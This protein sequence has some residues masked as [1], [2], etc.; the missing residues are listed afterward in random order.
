MPPPTI[1]ISC[2]DVC[3]PSPKSLVSLEW[4]RQ[5]RPDRKNPLA[6]QCLNIPEIIFTDCF[7]A[8]NQIRGRIGWTHQAPAVGKRNAQSVYHIN[9]FR[10]SKI[11]TINELLHQLKFLIFSNRNLELRGN[12]T[13]W[14]GGK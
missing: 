7:K 9:F 6:K 14:N 8:K 1:T 11:G 12:Q 2:D 10:I 13:V 5:I 4:Q 3:I